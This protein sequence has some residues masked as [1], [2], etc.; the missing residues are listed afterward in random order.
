MGSIRLDVPTWSHAWLLLGG[1][2][3][4]AACAV[5][6]VDTVEGPEPPPTQFSA[7][8][9]AAAAIDAYGVAVPDFSVVSPR[10]YNACGAAYAVDV[11]M[12]A[13]PGQVGQ[14]GGA[15][16]H[17]DLLVSYA[18]P[19]ATTPPACHALYGAAYF[20]DDVTGSG[21][22]NIGLKASPG[23]WLHQRAACVAPQVN[24]RDFDRYLDPYV[25][26]D[27]K[28]AAAMRDS[29]QHPLQ[30]KVS[31][32]QYKVTNP[33]GCSGGVAR[34]LMDEGLFTGQAM[35][36]C[37][38]RFQLALQ[39]DGNL[40]LAQRDSQGQFSVVL[41]SSQTAGVPAANMAQVAP[42]GN[43]SISALDGTIIW[44]S[45]TPPLPGQHLELSD[46]GDMRLADAVQGT[47]WDTNTG[48]H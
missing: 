44:F 11:R 46:D 25:G 9:C 1:A 47:A 26:T 36:S 42:D 18:G 43:L 28:I 3:W 2:V 24:L 8:D 13:R 19:A 45:D 34:M 35:A 48:G 27:I 31:T 10:T 17:H 32:V 39:P 5:D 14:A 16:F 37:D 20:Y 23:W 15:T 22:R 33:T 29:D 7:A 30:L 12:G 40:V 41:W 38:G 6:T 4:V 21:Y